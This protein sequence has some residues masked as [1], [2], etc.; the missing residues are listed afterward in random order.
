MTP[1]KTSPFAGRPVEPSLLAGVPKLS[2]ADC[3]QPRDPAVPTQPVIEG[4][5]IVPA[6]KLTVKALPL[7]HNPTVREA[8]DA[9]RNEGDPN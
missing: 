2:A 8:V 7:P 4:D 9:W 5:V 6:S 3:A 1:V